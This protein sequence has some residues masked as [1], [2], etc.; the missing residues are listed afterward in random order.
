MSYVSKKMVGRV[1]YEPIQGD[2][3]VRLD[4]NESPFPVPSDIIKSFTALLENNSLDQI[5]RAHV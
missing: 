4:A 2:Y 5:G 1:P 3:K